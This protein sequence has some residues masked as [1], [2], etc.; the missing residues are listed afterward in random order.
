MP[1]TLLYVGLIGLLMMVLSMRVIRARRSEG[2]S[3]G[4]GDSAMLERRIRAQGNLAEYGPL[5]LIALMVLEFNGLSAPFLH[6]LGALLVA[7]RVMHG[8][9]L[10]FTDGNAIGRTGG[11]VLTLSMLGISSLTCLRLFFAG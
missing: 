6:G 5:G 9:A 1:V 4:A 11:M 3:L 8:W 2:Q 7:G 10:S